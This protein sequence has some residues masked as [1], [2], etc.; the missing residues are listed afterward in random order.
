MGTYNGNKQGELRLFVFG[1]T[2]DG[3]GAS[4]ANFITDLPISYPDLTG[5][6][7]LYSAAGGAHHGET[8]TLLQYIGNRAYLDYTRKSI[9]SYSEIDPNG[10]VTNTVKEF[11][12]DPRAV[13]GI[14]ASGGAASFTGNHMDEIH[15]T[16]AGGTYQGFLGKITYPEQSGLSGSYTL[17]DLVAYGSSAGVADDPSSYTTFVAGQAIQNITNGSNAVIR[18]TEC[19]KYVDLDSYKEKIIQQVGASFDNN[20]IVGITIGTPGA[21]SAQNVFYKPNNINLLNY[22]SRLLPAFDHGGSGMSGIAGQQT[23]IFTLYAGATANL[24]DLD[25]VG[26]EAIFGVT[27]NAVTGGSMPGQSAFEEFGHKVLHK[28]A[29]TQNNKASV[30]HSIYKKKSVRDVDEISF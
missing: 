25:S 14:F 23:S 17:V 13:I 15:V 6:T 1:A 2:G 28:Y 30:I 16:T 27:F 26:S 4:G 29:E 19:V 10:G 18:D 3:T 9:R 20:D 5:A 22:V 11:T 12:P 7:A 8:A 21:A 24:G